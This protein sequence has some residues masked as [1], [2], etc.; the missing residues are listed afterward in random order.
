MDREQAPLRS[1]GTGILSGML[2]PVALAFRR[3]RG[4]PMAATLVALAVAG[5]TALVGWSSL[6]SALSHER[7]VRQRVAELPPDER[8]IQVVYHLVPFESEQASAGDKEVAVSVLLGDL[9]AIREA[10]QRVQLWSPID[11]GVRLVAAG[12]PQEAVTISDGRL[13]AGCADGVCEALALGGDFATGERIALTERVTI[14]VVGRGALRPE[15]YPSAPG[16]LASIPDPGDR[17]LLVSEIERPLVPLL[18]SSGS[19]VI[20]TA[21]LDPDALH[22]AELRSTIREVG[23][24]LVR[25]EQGGALV[26]AGAPLPLLADIARRGEIARERLLLIAGQG[27]VLILAFAAFA[28]ATRRSETRLLEE[29]LDTLGASRGQILASRVV[30]A[31]VPCLVGAL[32]A[33]IGLRVAAELV[34]RRRELPASFVDAAL[35]F[36]TVLAIV[37]VAAI[38]AGLLVAAVAPRRAR[39]GVGALELAAVT[40]LVFVGWQ[41]ATTGGL[42]PERIAAGQ[43]A[44]PVLLLLPA[45]A[46]F[47]TAVFVLRI[48]PATMRLAERASRRAPLGLRLAFLTASRSPA[49]AAAATTFLAVALGSAL[50]SLNYQATLERSARDE[51]RFAAGASWRVVERS[52]DDSTSTADVT[53][54]TRFASISSEEPTPVLRVG[55]EVR[56]RFASGASLPVEVL[57]LPSEQIRSLRGWRD[58]FSEASLPELAGL[59]RADPIQLRGIELADDASALRVWAR[60]QKGRPPRVVTLHFL[61]P[62]EQRFAQLEFGVITPGW[63][64][65]RVPLPERLRG[66]ELVGLEFSPTA[67]PPNGID[68][69][70]FVE[71]GRIDQRLAAGWSALP[72]LD[73][74][75]AGAPGAVV[76]APP[77]GAVI[78]APFQRAPV[79]RGIHVDLTSSSLPL[80][81]PATPLP[82]ALP[83]LASP[84]A[85][86]AQVSG[87]VTVD[88]LGRQLPLRIVG[89]TDLFPTVTER[90]ESFVVLDYATLFAALNVDQP[91]S[92]R[93]SE[94]W[95]FEAQAPDFADR[96]E[97]APFRLKE[98]VGVEPLT[99]RLL[100]DPLAAGTRDVL[101]LAAVG[102]AVLALL[103]L[104]LSARSALGSERLLLAE[105]EAMGVP[106]RTLARSAQMRLLLLSMLGV[107][108]GILGAIL[109]V[110][111]VGAFVAVTGASTRPLPP[112]EPIVAWGGVAIVLA[113]VAV[114]GLATA[115]FLAGRSLRETAARRLRA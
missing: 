29:Q 94:A 21:P 98:A 83:A 48:L 70:G 17:A 1:R 45:L 4:R 13:P 49:Q 51:A 52:A 10:P 91:G 115:A 81:R 73:S 33:V 38:A 20:T 88:L 44:G 84:S 53:P 54:L 25:T 28:A 106:P 6:A 60:S 58:D 26:E 78:A 47:A 43:G 63:E 36:S 24:A 85:A 111:M 93:P 80:I 12:D 2:T 35:P 66:A 96:L 101:G 95:F 99:A 68:P 90:P 75:E 15:A 69:G 62:E 59:L 67:V 107:A 71:L 42:D 7:N 56:E 112:V 82:E 114:A 34:A 27:A 65:L 31:F 72:A 64:R 87:T 55:G 102:A 77:S 19:S 113:A 3:M 37:A 32:G 61:F 39:F 8:A 110:R 46:F 16:A 108:A 30:E 41:A 104:V 18:R 86:A 9:A 5:A 23:R 40:A 79:G 57:A 109:A 22:G 103:G 89:R 92:A 105:Y 97:T 11:E 14:L 50:F 74:W 76:A 100:S